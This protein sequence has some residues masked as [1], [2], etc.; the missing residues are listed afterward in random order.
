[1]H[2][3]APV[4]GALRTHARRER[5]DGPAEPAVP[6]GGRAVRRSRLRTIETW[7]V[8][9]HSAVS[10]SPSATPPIPDHQCVSSCSPALLAIP[11]RRPETARS[12]ATPQAKA[13]SP[14]LP[15]DTT[16]HVGRLANGLRYWIR[17]N[18][19]PE[20]RLELRLVVRAGSILEDNDQRGLAHFI[21]HMGFNGTTHFARNEM[22][23][24]LESI[25]VKYG[26][27]LNANTVVRRNAVH[28][29]GAERQAGAGR[30]RLRHPAGLGDR[31]QVRPR[32]GGQRAR[33]RPG[34]VAQRTRRRRRGSSTRRSRSSS[35][36]RATP[37]ACRS[38]T[39]GSSPTP[40]RR[41]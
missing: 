14:A 3:G 12:S 40:P 17:H 16:V 34:R 38:A 33:R 28:P 15:V 13:S 4:P 9:P 24:Y 20:H 7:T 37:C 31:R 10:T 30:P 25:G 5:R 23:K 8:V 1:M 18:N 27:D 22:V 35:R 26:A 2:P 6:G 19:Y 41:R 29:A 32:R 11:A 39:P 21:E 36:A